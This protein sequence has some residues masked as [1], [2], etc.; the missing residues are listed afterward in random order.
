MAAYF[1]II[2]TLALWRPSELSPTQISVMLWLHQLVGRRRIQSPPIP[3]TRP[4]HRLGYRF[5]PHHHMLGP[6]IIASWNTNKSTAYRTNSTCLSRIPDEAD[7]RTLPIAWPDHSPKPGY[8]G[9]VYTPKCDELLNRL[10]PASR[11][12]ATIT[13]G[14]MA[15]VGWAPRPHSHRRDV[16]GWIVTTWNSPC[17]RRRR[18][19]TTPATRSAA[20]NTSTHRRGKDPPAQLQSVSQATLRR[21]RRRRPAIP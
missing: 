17:Q 14:S 7:L 11:Y 1:L 2:V 20:T 6:G 12:V 5:A 13:C 16:P 19:C 15:P 18:A 3:P 9:P 8:S 21:T 4:R 10:P